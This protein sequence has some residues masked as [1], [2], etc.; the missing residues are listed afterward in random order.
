MKVVLNITAQAA[1]PDSSSLA[2][3]DVHDRIIPGDPPYHDGDEESLDEWG[4]RDSGFTARPN[5]PGT[6][7]P[8]PEDARGLL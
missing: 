8:K 6:A 2:S 3:D 4:F 1:L 7:D 5:G